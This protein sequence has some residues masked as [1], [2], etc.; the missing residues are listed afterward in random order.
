[1]KQFVPEALELQAFSR[2]NTILCDILEIVFEYN[3]H[4]NYVDNALISMSIESNESES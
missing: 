4:Y 3:M 1:M 2:Y